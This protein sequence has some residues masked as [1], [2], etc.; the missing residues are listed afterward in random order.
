MQ[1]TVNGVN[2]NVSQAG[3]GERALVFM[4]FWG[5]SSRE[6]SSVIEGLSTRFHC[7]APDLPPSRSPTE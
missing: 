7:V 6:W 4:H 5:G 1:V 3:S 2:L